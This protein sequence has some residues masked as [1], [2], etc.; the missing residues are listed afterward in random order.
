[1]KKQRGFSL[2]E[3]II[4][5]SIMGIMAGILGPVFD[6]VIDVPE[7]GNERITAQH[8]LQ[9]VAHHVNIDGQM[10]KSATGGASL[11]LTMPDASTITYTLNSTNLTR[12]T[13][14]VN[15][16][17]AR[18]ITDVSFSVSG[19]YVTV[20]ITSSPEG[21]WDVNENETYQI[22]LRPVTKK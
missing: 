20:D 22:C 9:N 7:Y 16:V 12:S 5:I 1:M 4:T 2:I 15:T 14:G 8:E 13:G 19:R 3:L 18:N 10:A 6:Q 17:L 21:R 11:V